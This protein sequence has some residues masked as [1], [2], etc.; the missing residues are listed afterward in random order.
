MQRARHFSPA[1]KPTELPRTSSAPST[2]DA[3]SPLLAMV[4]A[5]AHGLQ[6]KARL[7]LSDHDDREAMLARTAR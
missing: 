3:Q 5:M 7:G 2:D 6:E 1:S 4:T